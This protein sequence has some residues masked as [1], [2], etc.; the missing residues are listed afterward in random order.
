MKATALNEIDI[1]LGDIVLKGSLN[2]VLNPRG[3]VVFSH[4]SGSSRLSS[5]NNYVANELNKNGLST[6]LFDLLMVKENLI[7]ENRFDIGLLTER[8]IKV[9]EWVL[10]QKS[11]QE[12]NIGYFGA[13][14]GAASALNAAATLGSK[15]RAIVLRGGRPDLA[16][17]QELSKVSAP[18]LF[19]VG[20]MDANVIPMN[21]RAFEKIK[22]V[23]K[24][25]IVS[26]ATHLFEEPGKLDQVTNL[27]INW[28]N[29]NL[30]DKLN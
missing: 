1:L 3:M 16:G 8:L 25:E 19:I 11:T 28:S 5:R 29:E 13:S 4:G 7:Y 22:T 26:G 30:T 2:L 17:N 10:T 21:Q 20:E 9:S 12:L 15:I 27:S 24:L 18:T 6:L 14:T 23:K